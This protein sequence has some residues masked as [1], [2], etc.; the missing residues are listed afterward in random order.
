LR[1]TQG[2]VLRPAW[3]EEHGLEL[4]L[5]NGKI[6]MINDEPFQMKA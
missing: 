1:V 4:E 3:D 5:E 2:I 6:T